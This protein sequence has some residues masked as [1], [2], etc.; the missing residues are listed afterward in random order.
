VTKASKTQRIGVEEI[1][2]SWPSEKGRGEDQ[3][4]GGK[5]L[6][7]RDGPPKKSEIKQEFGKGGCKAKLKGEERG[8][9]RVS[10]KGDKTKDRQEKELN[11]IQ[12]RKEGR[13]GAY[14]KETSRGLK[15]TAHRMN[16]GEDSDYSPSKLRPQKV[17]T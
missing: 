15:E 4:K 10:V 11:G 16:R 12:T 17:S 3:A 13:E 6:H 5:L 7:K 14:Q 8:R 1:K 2:P 9:S